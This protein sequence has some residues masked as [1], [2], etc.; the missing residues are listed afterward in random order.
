MEEDGNVQDEE[1][2]PGPSG[3]R[4]AKR[5]RPA[6]DESSARRKRQRGD[7]G[8]DEEE[9]TSKKRRGVPGHSLNFHDKDSGIRNSN[10]E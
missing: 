7:G 4:G 5:N 9:P 1:D 3:G 6:V 8:E 2:E 10:A